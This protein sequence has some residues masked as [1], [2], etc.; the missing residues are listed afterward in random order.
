MHL[1]DCRQNMHNPTKEGHV[2]LSMSTIHVNIDR[3]Y[4]LICTETQLDTLVVFTSAKGLAS[5]V[6]LYDVDLL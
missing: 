3:S 1:T 4:F 2:S 5:S 6:I